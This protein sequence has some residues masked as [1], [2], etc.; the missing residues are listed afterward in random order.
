MIPTP[1]PTRTLALLL[2][3]VSA[4]AQD[5]PAPVHKPRAPRAEQPP[6][7]VD[8][9]FLDAAHGGDDE[10]AHLGPNSLEKDATFAFA[11]RLRALLNKDGFTVVMA[12]AAS[13]NSPALDGRV[14]LAN[15]SRAVAC[16]L[17]HAANGG[18]GVHLYT[19]ALGAPVAGS[20]EAT[21]PRPIVPWDTAQAPSLRES[22]QLATDFATALDGTR[23]PLVAG[24]ASI[25]PIDSMTCPAIV[26][27]LAPLA[28]GKSQ[29]I[30]SDTGYQDRV[31]QAIASGLNAWR[32]HAQ[33]ELQTQA[34]MQAQIQAQMQTQN[35][36]QTQAASQAKAKQTTPAPKSKPAKIPEETPDVLSPDQPA[37]HKPAPILRRPPGPA[38]APT[39][40][41]GALR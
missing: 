33:A 26:V 5:T 39:P 22:Q 7:N 32:A 24:H 3:A 18:H 10:G 17:I 23:I 19:S 16:L 1:H 21:G 12:R 40:P 13:A 8:T 38:P 35:Q 27:E 37:P 15:R 31:A 41:T 30:A 6:Y 20:A 28:S 14:E 29:T 9:V 36:T 2:L 34:Q 11:E 25:K 4:L